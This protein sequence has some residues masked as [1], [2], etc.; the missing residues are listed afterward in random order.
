ME[1]IKTA[2]SRIQLRVSSRF[3][4]GINH[5]WKRKSMRENI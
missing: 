3:K 5:L 2:T 4:F 1:R